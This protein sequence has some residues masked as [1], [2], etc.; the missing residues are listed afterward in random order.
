MHRVIRCD[1]TGHRLMVGYYTLATIT[2]ASGCYFAYPLAGLIVD[3]VLLGGIIV[4]SG[5]TL[6]YR[7]VRQ[8]L[9]RRWNLPKSIVSLPNPPKFPLI[10]KPI[11]PMWHRGIGGTFFLFALGQLISLGF[12]CAVTAEENASPASTRVAVTTLDCVYA[13]HDHDL[14]A[15]QWQAGRFTFQSS[16]LE[17]HF[18]RRIPGVGSVNHARYNPKDPT[19]LTQF[20]HLDLAIEILAIY[21]F[22]LGIVDSIL[23]IVYHRKQRRPYLTRMKEETL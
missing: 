6:A 10:R 19:Q 7:R 8:P 17:N 2:V 14:C 16:V 4:L 22:A 13:G 3:I 23:F 9:L 5:V 20:N 1:Q 11:P 15:I 21:T 12:I 18:A